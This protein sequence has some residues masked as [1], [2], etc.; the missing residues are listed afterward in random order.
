M[1][2]TSEKKPN[3][4]PGCTVLAP[5]CS[6]LCSPIFPFVLSL[7]PG[8]LVHRPCFTFTVVSLSLTYFQSCFLVAVLCFA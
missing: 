4:D 3:V 7:N 1:E 6:I 5:L 2:E 8:P